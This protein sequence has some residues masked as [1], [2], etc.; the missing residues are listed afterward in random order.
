MSTSDTAVKS[1]GVNPEAAFRIDFFERLRES[2][3]P[4]CVLRN[5]DQ[6]PYRIPGHDIDIL[7]ARKLFPLCKLA[8]EMCAKEYNAKV[9]CLDLTRDDVTMCVVGSAAG[10]FWA[11]ILDFQTSLAWKGIEFF[12]STD[13]LSHAEERDGIRRASREDSFTVAVLN[14][15]VRTGRIKD[16]YREEV[17]REIEYEGFDV[18]KRLLRFLDTSSGSVLVELLCGERPSLSRLRLWRLRIWFLTQAL[19]RSPLHTFL[20]IGSAIVDFFRRRL[21]PPGLTVAVVGVD[22]SGKS[23]AIAEVSKQL[24][25]VLHREV[26][27]K[28]LRPGLLPRPGAFIGIKGTVGPVA[29]PHGRNA[30][31]IAGSIL[32][33]IY[34][35]LD[36]IVG[37]WLTVRPII[38]STGN[39]VIFDRYFHDYLVDPLRHRV[40]LP[41]S[42]V[43]FLSIFIPKP[44]LTF[45]LCCAPAIICARKPELPLDEIHNQ[46][47]KL[48]CLAN[49]EPHAVLVDASMC[50]EEVSV[51]MAELILKKLAE[52]QR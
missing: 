49:K 48:R 25:H 9:I 42:I 15:T 52:R 19:R 4:Y 22:G 6:L 36:Y 18:I 8:V 10:E 28:Q 47:L 30:R 34:H 21:H 5:H 7:V 12:I 11:V 3:I 17:L 43:R 31:G 41:E 23:S 35:T 27:V 51:I 20:S 50:K 24:R 26:V 39:V 45:V 40:R 46:Q 1:V 33:L 2:N 37:Y 14:D 44:Q 13:V 32:L 38:V 29:N 16:R